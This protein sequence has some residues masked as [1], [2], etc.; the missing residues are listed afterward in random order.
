MERQLYSLL[1]KSH[2]TLRLSLPFLEL[3][4][5]NSQKKISNLSQDRH[6]S[7]SRGGGGGGATP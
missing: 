4:Q 3:R 5:A 2:Q 7:G 1:D 6:F